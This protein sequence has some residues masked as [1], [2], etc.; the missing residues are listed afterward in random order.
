MM[1]D[2][3]YS[4]W[5][6]SVDPEATRAARGRIPDLKPSAEGC[7]CGHCLNF[8]AQRETIYPP[9]LLALF[10]TLGLDYRFE[11]DVSHIAPTGKGLHHY[12]VAFHFVGRIQQGEDCWVRSGKRGWALKVEPLREGI[13]LGFSKRTLWVPDELKG[14]PVLQMELVMDIPWVT[15]EEEPS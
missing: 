7:G 4:K 8:A 1:S 13:S 6:L 14:Q 10:E 11:A 5:T 15:D 9:E 12:G 3:Q 2:L